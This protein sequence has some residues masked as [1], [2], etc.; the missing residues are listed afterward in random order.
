MSRPDFNP[1]VR[2]AQPAVVDV[3]RQMGGGVIS[4]RGEPVGMGGSFSVP[5]IMAR[6]AYRRPAHDPGNRFDDL[7]RQA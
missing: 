5:E 4:S 2:R 1:D 6:S 7:E 3:R